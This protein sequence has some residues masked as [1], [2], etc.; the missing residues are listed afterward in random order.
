MSSRSERCV[1]K[2]VGADFELANSILGLHRAGGTGGLAARALLREIDGVPATGGR[3]YGARSG[4]YGG[5]G[6][7]NAQDLGRKFLA[8]NG[9]AAYIDLDHL[10]LCIPEVRSA[11][12]HAAACAAMLRI[13]R[14]A[15][16]R[17]D[18]KL[19][20]GQRLVVLVN[21]SDGLSNSYGSHLNVLLSRSAW[22]DIA[23]IRRPHHLHLLATHQLSSMILSGQGKVGAENDRPRVRYQISQRADFMETLTG[24]Q[25]T[26]RRPVVNTRDE[27]LCGQRPD[28]ARL[29]VISYDE[30]LAPGAS[31]LK[32]GTLQIVL[33]MLEAEHVPAG[34]AID[35]PVEAAVVWSHDP[36]L[37]AAVRRVAGPPVTALEIQQGLLEAAL[38]HRDRHGLDTVPRADDILALWADTLS[39]LERR[40]WSGLAARLDWVLKRQIL[41]RALEQWRDLDW[42]SPEIKVLDQLYSSLDPDEGLYWSYAHS[43]LIEPLI[44]E[45]Q[46]ERL[47]EEPT[48]IAW[49]WIYPKTACGV[50]SPS[51]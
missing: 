24:P 34:L 9:G 50:A 35:D 5:H 41:E 23:E 17:A 33:A 40:D 2:L 8:T 20:D 3:G 15:Q 14:C 30:T 1:P 12:D 47:C 11:F 10:E 51:T 13:A 19:P 29:H 48:G 26:H 42:G 43:G 18:Q 36:S 21:N 49:R 45:A 27:G 44:D 37:R 39:K 25:T 22:E 7:T 28:L 31:I 38:R 32:V 6:W 16:V 4:W 46:V